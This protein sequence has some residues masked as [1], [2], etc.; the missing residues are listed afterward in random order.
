MRVVLEMRLLDNGKHSG[1]NVETTIL[2]GIDYPPEGIVLE[3]FRNDGFVNAVR[4]PRDGESSFFKELRIR[5]CR[6]CKDVALGVEQALAQELPILAGLGEAVHA[7]LVQHFAG[8]HWAEEIPYR[9][10]RVNMAFSI[11]ETQFEAGP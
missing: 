8:I 11:A 10:A 1:V 7:R 4:C 5:H 2:F 3:D 9:N 6:K